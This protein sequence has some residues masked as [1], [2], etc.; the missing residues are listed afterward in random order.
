MP[1]LSDITKQFFP[2]S[3]HPYTLS[4]FAGSRKGVGHPQHDPTK[5]PWSTISMGDLQ[6]TSKKITFKLLFI[7][8][9]CFQKPGET[10]YE[11]SQEE[12]DGLPD[13]YIHHLPEEMLEMT[14][15]Q[16][17]FESTVVQDDETVTSTSFQ[18]M[19]LPQ[20][21]G[22]YEQ[23]IQ[24]KGQYDIIIVVSP[25]G[26]TFWALGGGLESKREA[27]WISISAPS[28]SIYNP[29]EIPPLDKYPNHFAG[30]AHE[31][32]H[33]IGESFYR[34][35]K[36]VQNIP[37]V[38]AGVAFGYH[39]SV[40]YGSSIVYDNWQQWYSDYYTGT[41]QRNKLS[42]TVNNLTYEANT[43]QPV[44]LSI[45]ASGIEEYLN[46]Q[47]VAQ[48]TC[49]VNVV[50]RWA[51]EMDATLYDTDLEWGLA[52]NGTPLSLATSTIKTMALISGDT[53]GIVVNPNRTIT[54]YDKSYVSITIDG[55]APDLWG[56]GADKAYI[57]HRTIRNHVDLVA[58]DYHGYYGN[59]DINVKESKYFQVFWGNSTLLTDEALVDELLLDLEKQRY[60]FVE[61]SGWKN[62]NYT[63]N[64]FIDPA[65]GTTTIEQYKTNV[66][67]TSTGL[68]QHTFGA[69]LAFDGVR[70]M[71]HMMTPAGSNPNPTAFH[72]YGHVI[73]VMQHLSDPSK[74]FN[75]N[76]NAG[77]WWESLAEWFFNEFCI[78][79]GY[80]DTVDMPF[81][82]YSKLHL[83]MS[84]QTGVLRYYYNYA[85]LYYLYHNPDNIKGLGPGIIVDIVQKVDKIYF[86][87]AVERRV[88][89]RNGV[90]EVQD[91]LIKDILGHYTK[92][93][94]TQEFF[95]PTNPN[96]EG[97][98]QKYKQYWNEFKGSFET[99]FDFS[100]S[101]ALV[102]DSTYPVGIQSIVQ[103]ETMDTTEYFTLD[104]SSDSIRINSS[105]ALSVE[106][107][108]I[109]NR[110]PRCDTNLK[111]TLMVNGSNIVVPNTDPIK[112]ISVTDGDVVQLI[113]EPENNMLQLYSTTNIQ[114]EI[115]PEAS[116]SKI[117]TVPRG[118]E[119]EQTGRAV[120]PL[121]RYL[122]L[123]K[124]TTVIVHPDPTTVPGLQSNK[125]DIVSSSDDFR[126]C[127]VTETASGTV[128][129]GTVTDASV[130][131]RVTLNE[132]DS[133]WLTLVATPDLVTTNAFS[134]FIQTGTYKHTSPGKGSDFGP[135]FLNGRTGTS[136][137][138]L[139]M[140]VNYD[141]TTFDTTTSN[142]PP[143]SLIA[144]PSTTGKSF[145]FK[146]YSDRYPDLKA[147]FGDDGAALTQHWLFS[148]IPE[149]RN[150]APDDACG[151]F[152]TTNYALING[153]Y[154]TEAQ[155]LEHYRTVG[156]WEGLDYCLQ[157]EYYFHATTDSSK[158]IFIRRT[159]TN[160]I[161]V[162]VYGSIVSFISTL[163]SR[164]SSI[165]VSVVITASGN[166]YNVGVYENFIEK[167]TSTI[168]ISPFQE[169]LTQV[170]FG[171][172]HD[173]T[174][175]T[176]G[177]VVFV[178]FWESWYTG[179][180]DELKNEY[181][182]T[183]LS[184]NITTYLP[185]YRYS[186]ELQE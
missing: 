138:V 110:A 142:P 51:T 6:A 182:P 39:K 148:G 47:F 63:I 152:S 37:D 151:P 115:I 145:D 133:M 45:I 71:G 180:F 72:E 129:Y 12:L 185:K 166:S 91:T 176:V 62:P 173:G 158:D 64:G 48:Q 13:E 96:I 113:V 23:Y 83:I 26:Q 141:T 84:H 67:I 95:V 80:L 136:Q 14:D 36:N 157:E 143:S 74:G 144:P 139:H 104:A 172:T 125:L 181:S 79:M 25:K 122:T 5:T 3:I 8:K 10:L 34:S 43:M 109:G 1:R 98:M 167:Q 56:L 78:Y 50:A 22:S 171:Q 118:R 149:G 156:V 99:I 18:D 131:D 159:S 132:G 135:I 150:G 44:Q 85:F 70:G 33:I 126:K 164:I 17:V 184:S 38:H 170:S 49:T 130:H 100:A 60:Y 15:N 161:E 9:K 107:C 19:I 140:S 101:I 165:S 7:L 168:S 94:P 155:L 27:G 58:Y 65:T 108:W 117:Y 20:D 186:V 2:T 146:A 40:N 177:D 116:S 90:A 54:L 175:Q 92:R 93:I 30:I 88:Q 97:V 61:E 16:V 69:F 81:Q 178:G 57:P 82:D 32:L 41:I 123:G 174:G 111:W 29:P 160:M 124:E 55:V 119:L 52:L 66:Y 103:L 153:L 11:M 102:H 179:F 162:G 31:M 154:G 77:A 120:I 121:H 4:Q 86:F 59:P 127:I 134:K 68:P 53:L 76:D 105:G 163:S 28:V 87:H 137:V 183:N 128:T 35:R 42:A 24:Y 106:I 89:Q 169:V 73:T 46:N 147:A 75:V 21:A 114:M 112:D